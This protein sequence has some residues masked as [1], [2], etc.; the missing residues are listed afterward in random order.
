MRAYDVLPGR[1]RFAPTSLSDRALVAWG[2]T[3]AR[4]GLALRTYIHPN[5]IRTL[6]WD[7]HHAASVRPM[8]DAVTDPELRRLTQRV[9]DRYDEVVAPAWSALP[10]QALHGDLTT[11]N[12]LADDD[13][14]ITGIIDFGDLSYTARVVDLASVLDCLASG[15]VGDEMLRVARLAL[16]GYERHTPLEERELAIMGELWAARSAVGVAIGSWRSAQGLEE[17]DYAQRLNVVAGEMMDFLLTTGWDAVGRRLGA[18]SPLRA[19]SSGPGWAERREAAFGP[20]M[21]SLSYSE[22]IEM[23]QASGMW[24]T[25]TAGRRY[26][27]M[28]NNVVGLGH[29]HPRVTSA[30][31]RQ[32]RVLNTNLRYL[33]PSA[34]ELAERLLET[35]PPGLDTV[36]LVNSGSEANDIAWRIAVHQTGNTG[37]LCTDFAYHGVTTVIA[38]L[39]PETIPPGGLAPHV[40]TWHPTDTYRGLW[41]DASDFTQALER[42]QG[43]GLRPAAAILDG[44]LQSDGVYDLEPAYVQELVRSHPRGGRPVDRGR[45]PGRPRAHR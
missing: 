41:T 6:P 26:L 13:G 32:W 38:D 39:S 18:E 35:C 29:A 36:L 17:A 7:V 27:D 20:A 15:R 24:M 30:V 42:L 2:E 5:M 23:A 31:S 25:D 19:T 14:F 37:G 1:S 9:L 28:Y 44:V 40:E 33:H 12:V 34:V 10:S 21:E 8:L 3:T 22:P 16:D 43:R 4:L 45:G 11:D